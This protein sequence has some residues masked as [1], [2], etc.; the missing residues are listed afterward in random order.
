MLLHGEDPVTSERILQ[1]RDII[2]KR[3]TIEVDFIIHSNRFETLSTNLGCARR[4]IYYEEARTR[5]LI[6][7]ATTLAT[8]IL[9]SEVLVCH[10]RTRG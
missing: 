3:L 6:V 5:E 9:C 2:S 8:A 1:R 4:S 10:Y 7:C